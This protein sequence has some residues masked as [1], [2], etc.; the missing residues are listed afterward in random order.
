[1]GRLVD[2]D[3]GG[4]RDWSTSPFGGALLL[5]HI[6]NVTVSVQTAAAGGAEPDSIDSIKLNAP[7]NYSAQNRAVTAADY[8]AIVPTVYSNVQSLAVWGGEN[9][10]PPI[11]GKIYISIYLVQESS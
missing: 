7:F 6:S 4:R 5:P 11:Y 1:M 3:H 2:L 9:N 8:K 10:D